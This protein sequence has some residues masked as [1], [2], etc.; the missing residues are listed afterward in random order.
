MLTDRMSVVC[1]ILGILL[2]DHI[3]VGGDNREY[4]SFREKDILPMKA[5]KLQ[6]DYTK[7]DMDA[8]GVAEDHVIVR[9]RR[10]R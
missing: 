6:N 1:E 9:P 3:I 8:S 2:V 4:F 5:I 10:G 7:L